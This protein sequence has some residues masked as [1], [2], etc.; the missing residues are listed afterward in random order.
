[1]DGGKKEIRLVVELEVYPFFGGGSCDTCLVWCMALFGVGIGV[2][3][4]GVYAFFSFFPSSFVQLFYFWVLRL[5][6]GACIVWHFYG[7]WY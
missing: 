7:C 3:L 5:V 6:D 4:V 1:M 2:G